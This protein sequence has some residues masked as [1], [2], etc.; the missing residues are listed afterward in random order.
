[1]K[2]RADS[3]KNKIGKPL[4]RL[5]KKN[6]VRSQISKMRNGKGEVMTD[7]TEKQRII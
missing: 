3:L 6:R 1:M 2:L 7:T 5:I 4:V